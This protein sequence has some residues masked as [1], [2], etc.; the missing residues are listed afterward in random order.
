MATGRSMWG[1]S[2]VLCFIVFSVVVLPALASASENGWTYVDNRLAGVTVRPVFRLDETR[3]CGGQD[4]GS[5]FNNGSIWC[6]S[7]GGTWT[8]SRVG[9]DP[10]NPPVANVRDIQFLTS[11]VGWAVGGFAGF[12]S[13]GLVAK[14]QD[15]GATW[16]DFMPQLMESVNSTTAIPLGFL[17]AVSAAV[18][19]T[20]G[21]F[22][23]YS[24]GNGGTSW[25]IINLPDLATRQSQYDYIRYVHFESATAGQVITEEHVYVTTNG[26]STWASSPVLPWTTEPTYFEATAWQTL[27]GAHAYVLTR[28]TNGQF[29]L[30]HSET[31]GNRWEILNVSSVWRS[32]FHFVTPQEAYIGGFRYIGHSTDGGATWLTE[33][34]GTHDGAYAKF[35]PSLTG[36]PF[37]W[38]SEDDANYA[39]YFQPG[40]THGTSSGGVSYIWMEAESESD[41]DVQKPGTE[42][43]AAEEVPPP[44]S[45]G[46]TSGT[47][48]WYLS[49]QGDAVSYSF[50]VDAGGDYSLWLRDVGDARHP[51]GARAL[52]ISIDSIDL[53]SYN[54]PAP[55]EGWQWQ[56]IIERG[57]V[58]GQHT[59]RLQKTE[60][61]SAAAIVDAILFT[62]DASF[63]PTGL[64]PGSTGVQGGDAVGPTL[65]TETSGT[66]NRP[67]TANQ[68]GTNA[69]APALS[70][71]FVLAAL[72]GLALARG[73]LRGRGGRPR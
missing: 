69:E 15:G 12:G 9:T 37:V 33:Y 13:D 56:K 10:T 55:G 70:A 26:G 16:T 21:D 8:K 72:V 59:L 68:T 57:L 51:F 30:R 25:T 58:P 38:S 66:G 27:D 34:E 40:A 6:L 61:T 18:A 5:S 39:G 7:G 47:G 17:S 3:F 29:T 32:G 44:A 64:V 73:T 23:L 49:R 60:T 65:P 63:V 20:A 62:T 71:P 43:D 54:E 2:T 22:V 42:W 50:T 24:T 48:D 53:G 67:D 4:S 19:F 28:A 11:Q 46:L 14:T 31:G 36:V 35:R 1:S 41:A 52:T 45:R